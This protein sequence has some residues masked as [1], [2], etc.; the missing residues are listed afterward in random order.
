MNGC[1]N[2]LW[3]IIIKWVNECEKRQQFAI[4]WN[5]IH[6]ESDETSTLEGWNYKGHHHINGYS[7]GFEDTKA[8]DDKIEKGYELS[9]SLAMDSQYQGQALLGTGTQWCVREPKDR[10]VKI[11]KIIGT[12]TDLSNLPISNGIIHDSQGRARKEMMQWCYFVLLI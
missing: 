3:D 1:W 7:R 9:R 4:S 11:E 2:S 8:E 5:P 12:A 10:Q 6:R